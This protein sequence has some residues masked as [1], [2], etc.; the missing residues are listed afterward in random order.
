MKRE[1]YKE[2]YK[3]KNLVV[4]VI[5]DYFFRHG[6]SL[7]DTLTA[8]LELMDHDILSWDIVTAKFV[9]RVGII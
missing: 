6:E 3:H 7:A 2:Q 1:I 8:F 4:D 5:S 9:K